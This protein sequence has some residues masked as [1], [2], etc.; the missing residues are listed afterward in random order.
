MIRMQRRQ[1]NLLTLLKL[2]LSRSLKSGLSRLNRWWRTLTQR[3]HRTFTIKRKR[4]LIKSKNKRR[5]KSLLKVRSKNILSWKPR[6]WMKI[7][8]TRWL[9]SKPCPSTTKKW[10]KNSLSTLRK[11]FRSKCTAPE[12][13]VRPSRKQCPTTSRRC[14]GACWGSTSTPRKGTKGKWSKGLPA[15]RQDAFPLPLWLLAAKGAPFIRLVPTMSVSTVPSTRE[16]SWGRLS[17]TKRSLTSWG[18]GQECGEETI[19]GISSKMCS[20]LEVSWTTVH[21]NQILIP[22]IHSW[23]RI[24]LQEG[25]IKDSRYRKQ[26]GKRT[27]DKISLMRGAIQVIS[28]NVWVKILPIQTL[29]YIREVFLNKPKYFLIEVNLMMLGTRLKQSS[30]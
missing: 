27:M 15:W 2:N 13:T 9:P 16:S 29:L 11:C 3:T 18:I 30:I 23:S 28:L 26:L 17:T 4:G 25:K 20:W 12:R 6:D 22:W 10:R 1:G 19:W 5:L 24:K 7:R 21:L 14:F 8:K